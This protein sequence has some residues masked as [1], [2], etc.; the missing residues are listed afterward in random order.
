MHSP[1]AHVRASLSTCCTLVK[2]LPTCFQTV[3]AAHLRA[4]LLICRATLLGLLPNIGAQEGGVLL[5]MLVLHHLLHLV[6][7]PGNLAGGDLAAALALSAVQ[8]RGA[9]ETE[10]GV[11]GCNGVCCSLGLSPAGRGRQL[12]SM[13][14]TR[15]SRAGQDVCC[16]LNNCPACRSTGTCTGYCPTAQ[17]WSSLGLRAWAHQLRP[18]FLVV[19]D[20]GCVDR[21]I[22]ISTG[23]AADSQ[24]CDSQA[25][26]SLQTGLHLQQTEYFR[27]ACALQLL[28]LKTSINLYLLLKEAFLRPTP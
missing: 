25:A 28:G 19:A 12:V 4:A 21:C 10:R 16:S 3:S 7:V 17:S 2:L 5:P 23:H 13:L 22:K 27:S 15:R 14:P 1:L 9:L 20:C 6:A 11:A 8:P 26:T 18:P 24:G